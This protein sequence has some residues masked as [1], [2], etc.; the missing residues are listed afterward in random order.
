MV[1][2]VNTSSPR[3]TAHL[4]HHRRWIPS[5]VSSHKTLLLALWIAFFFTLFIWQQRSAAAGFLIFRQPF[6]YRP[7]PKLRPVLFNLTD[8]G[9]VGDGVTVNTVAFERAMMAISKLG[10]KGG[11]QLNV[12]PGYWLTAPFNLT[13]HLTLFLAEGAEILGINVSN[14]QI[15]LCFMFLKVKYRILLVSLLHS[16]S[17]LVPCLCLLV[18]CL[19]VK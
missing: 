15:C 11:G 5:F 7:F 2:I 6:S 12:P 8:F 1:E 17:L 10:K 18:I 3:R 16:G 19:L 4:H 9:A 14:F 13:S